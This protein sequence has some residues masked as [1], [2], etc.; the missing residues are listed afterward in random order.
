M[1]HRLRGGPQGKGHTPSSQ[2]NLLQA[3]GLQHATAAPA[4]TRL[5]P[6]RCRGTAEGEGQRVLPA[7]TRSDTRKGSTKRHVLP[8]PGRARSDVTHT[9]TT[10][11]TT[12]TPWM[13]Q[14]LWFLPSSSIARPW[15]RLRSPA[16][17]RPMTQR[18][19]TVLRCSLA[20][21]RWPRCW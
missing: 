9:A 16:C 15:T 10:T 5:R 18:T 11:I 3:R 12:T 6:G 2:C 14:S 1:P 7:T 8:V 20:Q 13:K 17:F 4:A 19:A 21:C